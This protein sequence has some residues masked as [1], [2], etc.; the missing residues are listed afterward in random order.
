MSD[1]IAVTDLAE[2][3]RTH[4]PTGQFKPVPFYSQVGDM[5]EVYWDEGKPN[6]G[7]AERVNDQ[8][9]VIRAFDDDRP[10]GVKVY[11]VLE[12]VRP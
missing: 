6:G 12:L 1:A 9:T 7:Y 3:L 2:Y 4:P 5:L 10:I 11:G 8:L